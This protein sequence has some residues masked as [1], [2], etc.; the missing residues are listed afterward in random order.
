MIAVEL[1]KQLPRLRTWFTLGAAASFALVLTGALGLAGAG[2]AETVGD[3][4]LQVVPTASG[5]AIPL[6]ALTSTMKF[7][8]PLAVSIF[9]GDAVAAEVRWGSLRY[10]LA[11]GVSRT[12][13][14]AAKA[15]VAALL[16]LAAVTLVPLVALAAG[17]FAFGWRPL[18]VSD[19]SAV[20]A[21]AAAIAFDPGTALLRLGLATAYVAAGMTSI[22][23]FAL[24]LSAV[25]GRTLVAVAGGVGLTILSRVFNAD[26]LPGVAVLSAYSPNNDVDLWLHLFQQPIQTTGM[27]AFLLLQAIYGLVFLGLAWWWFI[28]RD[29]LT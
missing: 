2:R 21:G 18:T 17:A 12:H 26:Y 8:L 9:A 1:A 5:L 6:V 11:R 16:S 19:A 20:Q 29:V 3:I 15:G 13:L 14:L 23:A 10:A 27:T 24:F 7:F 25:T 22:F 4:P 28:R